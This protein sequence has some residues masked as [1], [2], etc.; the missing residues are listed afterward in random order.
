MFR[1]RT[2][3]KIRKVKQDTQGMVSF[4]ITLP[5]TIAYRFLEVSFKVIQSGDTILLM[6]GTGYQTTANVY[7]INQKDIKESKEVD[8]MERILKPWQNN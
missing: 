1:Q 6:S 7:P 8:K 3:Y 2:Y 4:G 5:K